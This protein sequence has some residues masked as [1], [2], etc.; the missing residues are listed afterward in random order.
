MFFSGKKQKN[1]R[2]SFSKKGDNF[3]TQKEYDLPEFKSETDIYGSYTGTPLYGEQPIQDV[4]D[5]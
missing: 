1:G 3:K 4:D 2:E 5:L